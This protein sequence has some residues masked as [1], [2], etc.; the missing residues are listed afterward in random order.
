MSAKF[1]E[2]EKLA[3][4]YTNQNP[5]ASY[6]DVYVLIPDAWDEKREGGVGVNRIGGAPL[7]ID[8]GGWPRF[9]RMEQLWGEDYRTS[10]L[11]YTGDKRME[12][13]FTVDLRQTPA[14]RRQLPKE[15]VA[16]SFFISNASY[17]SAWEAGNDETSVIFLTE[18][19]LAA[20]DYEGQLPAQM[21]GESRGFEIFPIKLPWAMF[22]GY[23]PDG[24]LAEL[25]RLL[26]NM[27]AYM[28]GAEIWLQ[29]EEGEDDYDD[30]G[31]YDDE[32]AD[33]ED[34]GGGDEVEVEEIPT[35]AR[36]PLR[37]STGFLMQFGE[38]FADVNLGDSGEMYVYGGD[39]FWQ[40]Y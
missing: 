14:V 19:H 11:P 16:M 7:G 2:L 15:V 28:G 1:E 29:G 5:S 23:Q 22:A 25:R 39:A 9:A 21:G 35:S 17:N 40:C 30:Y 37:F 33:D 26:F 18:E 34:E 20:G 32:G 31:D 24:P 13:V 3:K 8:D 38:A 10:K 12:H 27:P 6:V 36:M 4:E